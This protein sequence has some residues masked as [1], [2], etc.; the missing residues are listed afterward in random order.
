MDASL[1]SKDRE[2]LPDVL[3]LELS[4]E[5]SYI[6]E[7]EARSRRA[8]EAFSSPSDPDTGW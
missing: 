3:V 6:V 8:A 4:P 5:L 7:D 1:I 2:K